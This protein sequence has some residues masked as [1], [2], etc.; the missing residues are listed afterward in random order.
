MVE[1]RDSDVEVKVEEHDDFHIDNGIVENDEN[2]EQF[3]RH[4][5]LGLPKG[6]R[7]PWNPKV[8]KVPKVFKCDECDYNTTKSFRLKIHK[9]I[10]SGEK[11]Y[12]CDQC[13]Y[14]STHSSTLKQHKRKHTGEKAFKCQHFD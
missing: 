7:Y 6:S 5:N 4:S 12:K 2:S 13:D 11:P 14:S 10:H 8:P 3:E 9:R 1:S